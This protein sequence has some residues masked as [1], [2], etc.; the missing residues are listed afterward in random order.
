[1]QVSHKEKLINIDGLGPKAISSLIEYFSNNE[2]I[3][4]IK[5]LTNILTISNYKINF[6]K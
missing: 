6:K 2:N 5:K 3:K 4:T 1:M